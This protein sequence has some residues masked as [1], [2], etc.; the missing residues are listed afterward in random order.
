[1][2][3]VLHIGISSL[4][5][6]LRDKSSYIWLVLMP[7]VFA[8][9]M[10]FA[11]GGPR[12]P[13]NARPEVFIE[14]HDSGFMGELFLETLG[15]QGLRPVGE[16]RKENAKR[17]LT[18]PEDFT[19]KILAK[20]KGVF[21]F[22]KIDG[23]DDQRSFL[24]QVV[25]FRA[26]VAFNGYI[27]E[28]VTEEGGD[29]ELTEE[30]LRSMMDKANP[31]ELDARF[32]G[33]KPI[34]VGFNLSLPG[35]LVMY[36]MLNLMVFGGAGIAAE[37]RSG[38][39]RR[40]SINPISK[41]ELLYGKLFGLMLLACVQI[42]VFML[43]GQFVFGVNVGEN[44]PGILLT[45]L[46]FSWVAGSLGLLIGFLIKAEEKV[47]GLSLMIALPTAALG[48]CWWPLEVVPEYLQKLAFAFPTGWALDAL[49]QL[50][51]FGGD[52][53]N[54]WY[55]IGVLAVFGIVANGLAMR[56]FRV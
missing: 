42:F 37:R 8:Y 7:L 26:V 16:K 22:F 39:L 23:E 12:D 5:I 46:V 32:A 53:S 45:L 2:S 27:V 44:L 31:V 41:I 50:I 51:T 36:L 35:N 40:L 4:R 56:F 6:F 55:Q 48:G 13:A 3:K 25:V 9:F 29:A 11:A 14:N 20:E 18:I 24:A 33:R 54:V 21:D 30:G 15:K 47:I 1:M 34:P 43:M 49:H 19:E 38:I 28:Y 52:L 10:G 17:G